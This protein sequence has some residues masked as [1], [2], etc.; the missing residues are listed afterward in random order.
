[1]SV[2]DARL[3]DPA[4]GVLPDGSSDILDLWIEGSE[5]AKFWM[6]VFNDLKTRGVGGI[7][8]AVADGLKGMSEAM[9]TVYA[10][11]TLRTR[12][13]RQIRNSLTANWKDRTT[14]A[15]AL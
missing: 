12:I 7:L 10:A 4:F 5:G 3:H 2:A 8:I 13:V 14:P 9:A 11:T 1:V 15:A 6:K